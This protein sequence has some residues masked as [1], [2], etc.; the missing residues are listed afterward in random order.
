M[1]TT[2]SADASAETFGRALEGL[3]APLRRLEELHQLAERALGGDPLAAAQF[4]RTVDAMSTRVAADAAGQ[5]GAGCSCEP[6][7]EVAEASGLNDGKALLDEGGVAALLVACAALY[8][9][10]DPRRDSALATV[11]ALAI[12]ATVVSDMEDAVRSGDVPA[13]GTLLADWLG[14]HVG[15]LASGQQLMRT[16]SAPAMPAMPRWPG[17]GP[18]AP[19]RIGFPSLGDGL[20]EILG[21]LRRPKRPDPE[22]WDLPLIVHRDYAYQDWRGLPFMRCLR[23]VHE[24]I[25]A[26]AGRR[27]PEPPIMPT[28]SGGISSVTQGGPCAGNR[29]RIVGTDL[30]LPGAVFLLPFA[31]G[32]RRFEPATWTDTLIEFDLPPDAISGPMGFGNG[33][34]MAAYDAWAADQNRL[35]DEIERLPCLPP[36]LPMVPPF[37]GCPP[38]VGVNRLTAG[39]AII[40]TFTVNGQTQLVIETGQAVTLEWAVRNATQV[41]ISRTSTTGPLLGGGTSIT[42]PP[43][44]TLALGTLS[45]LQPTQCSYRL[46]AIGPCGSATRDVSIAVSRRPTLSIESVE[47]TQGIQTIP[48]TVELVAGKPTVVRVTVRHGIG[49]FA[50]GTVPG[51]TGSIR[52]RKQGGGES[53]PIN[54]ANGSARPMSPRPGASISVSSFPLRQNANDTLN[55][56]LPPD[57]SN[58]PCRYEIEVRV[59]GFGA[60]GTFPG[61]DQAVRYTTPEVYTFEPRRILD[62]RYGLLIW[63][64]QPVPSIADCEAAISGAVPYLPTPTA[65]MALLGM[66][67][68]SWTQGTATNANA[69]ADCADALYDQRN[70]DDIGDWLADLFGEC[71]FDDHVIWAYIMTP[72]IGGDAAAIPSNTLISDR[73]SDVLA[74]ELGHCLGQR[75]VNDGCGA[76]GGDNMADWAGG[77]VFDVPF[78]SWEN[79]TVVNARELMGYC[80]P[81]WTSPKRWKRLW[82]F[83]GP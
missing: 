18:P 56:V 8:C 80:T 50:G 26:R 61:F 20:A 65:N 79:A 37:R 77:A 21:K 32:C 54:A 4:R 12:E 60:V 78:D 62:I 28:W 2:L 46:T 14:R 57:E 82:D 64:G 72:E 83:I 81:L 11:M 1:A 19:P 55:F 68:A 47:V 44:P 24:K 25:R 36:D 30:K 42:N 63:N 40:D 35:A 74:H 71:P 31:D 73:R 43:P 51:V 34:Y 5:P 41:R 27:P 22:M 69:M 7:R 76:L 38:D 39:A 58:W 67:A 59:T 3:T 53:A 9:H 10:G 16:R 75:H 45:F 66:P 17:L 23:L 49:N 15:L 33:A 13:A 48:P 52:V 6:C 29:I 70:C